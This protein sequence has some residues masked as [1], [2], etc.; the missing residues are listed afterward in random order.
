M[1]SLGRE[2]RTLSAAAVMSAHAG[3]RCIAPTVIRHR[4]LA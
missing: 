4:C 3:E 1:N 2:E